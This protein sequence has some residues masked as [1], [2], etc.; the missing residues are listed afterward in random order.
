MSI[1]SVL[2]LD[3]SA[4][5]ITTAYV[6]GSA[7]AAGRANRILVAG[8]A[9]TVAGS[10]S[11]S[12]QW[13]LQGSYTGVDGTNVGW[14]DL[15]ISDLE[16]T[17]PA[18]ATSISKATGVSADIPMFAMFDSPCPFVRVAGKNTGGAGIAGEKLQATLSF[19]L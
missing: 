13:K 10:A 17:V 5:A 7:V 4:A 14:V 9:L 6:A 15:P 3:L 11:T 2:A 8:R 12:A 16:L 19:I 18:M 1:P